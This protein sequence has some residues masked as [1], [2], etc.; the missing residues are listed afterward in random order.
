M[1][2]KRMHEPL[3]IVEHGSNEMLLTIAKNSDCDFDVGWYYVDGDGVETLLPLADAFGWVMTQE[4]GDIIADL[5]TYTTVVDGLAAVRIPATVTE[6]MDEIDR[7]VWELFGVAS[8][9]GEQK[10]LLGGPVRV[11][12]DV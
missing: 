11:R 6:L 3:S 8:G 10:K 9:S 1:R 2:E 5:A 7:G 4:D 12:E